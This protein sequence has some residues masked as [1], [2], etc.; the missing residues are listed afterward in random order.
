MIVGIVIRI[1]GAWTMLAEV[2]WAKLGPWAIECPVCG[3]R[4]RRFLPAGRVGRPNA[5]CP[6]CGALER[7]RLLWLYLRRST[8]LFSVPGRILH[9][10]PEPC[11][12]GR[13]KSLRHIHYVGADLS[14]TNVAVAMD[15][16]NIPLSSES[17]D[18]ILCSHVLEHVADDRAA[19]SEIQRVLRP[20]GW[21]ILQVPVDETRATTFED[22]AITEPA[23]R[24]TL[25]GQSDHVRIYGRDYIER[26][27]GARFAVEVDWY[28]VAE[29]RDIVSLHALR[30]EALHVCR[31]PGAAR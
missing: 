28:P 2:L 4:F 31:K 15:I 1:R 5:R 3:W 24:E 18:V 10:A 23:L 21:A 6:R 8:D 13:L 26:L 11:L 27:R 20:G 16:Q 14:S 19:L 30:P 7:H 29:D 25:F 17:C 9:I 12:A 22:A